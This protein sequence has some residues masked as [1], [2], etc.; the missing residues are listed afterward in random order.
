MNVCPNCFGSEITS[1]VCPLCGYDIG[2]PNADEHALPPGT[3]LSDARYT[4]GGILTQSS[5]GITYYGFDSEKKTRVAVLEYFPDSYA[6]RC[7]TDG[8]YIVCAQKGDTAGDFNKGLQRFESETKR[9]LKIAKLP[10]FAAVLGLVIERGT[11]YIIMEFIDG[12]PLG[13]VI[14]KR[15]GKLSEKIA[16]DLFLPIIKTLGIMHRA[17]FIHRDITPDNILVQKS[18]GK[19]VLIDLGA[20]LEL[21]EEGGDTR[22]TDAML[23]FDYAA[24]ELFDRTSVRQGA[25]TDVYG[26][27][28]TMYI[29][30]TGKKPSDRHKS[31]RENAPSDSADNLS[32]IVKNA[33]MHGTEAEIKSRTRT[34]EQLYSELTGI[35]VTA[36]KTEF[37][38]KT[39]PHDD[40]HILEH[41]HSYSITKI[42]PLASYEGLHINEQIIYNEKTGKAVAFSHQKDGRGAGCN[43]VFIPRKSLKI[44]FPIKVQSVGRERFDLY[45]NQCEIEIDLAYGD[46]YGQTTIKRTEN[47]T[48]DSGFQFSYNHFTTEKFTLNNFWSGKKDGEEFLYDGDTIHKQIS[49]DGTKSPKDSKKYSLIEETDSHKDYIFTEK[50]KAV[51]YSET[52][53]FGSISYKNGDYYRGLIIGGEAC[54]PGVCVY[55]DG[56]IFIGHFVGGVPDGY[57]LYIEPDG[58]AFFVKYDEEDPL[59]RIYIGQISENINLLQSHYLIFLDNIER[60]I[61]KGEFNKAAAELDASK[62]SFTDNSEYYWSKLKI[63]LMVK[64]DNDLKHYDGFINHYSEYKNAFKYADEERRRYFESI[65]DAQAMNNEIFRNITKELIPAGKFDKAKDEMSKIHNDLIEYS[66]YWWTLLKINLKKKTDE[67]LRGCGVNITAMPEYINANK[68]ASMDRK[69]RYLA[70]AKSIKAKV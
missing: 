9:L 51:R 2:A 28:A 61:S 59:E 27:A 65:V 18:D 66:E 68:F 5:F 56:D 58:E 47:G 15:G 45:G 44:S 13:A 48:H 46:N 43:I 8:D 6:E 57:G 36:I 29:A 37:D 60:L 17:G 63:H 25:W 1:N 40:K 67:E 54:G 30:M 53:S 14:N 16:L 4:V 11:A 22:T 26:M 62:V 12:E 31:I 55:A 24:E 34:M 49:V 23:K 19:A 38:D 69:R 52:L 35:P 10:G 64:N 32:E 70:V 21:T 3:K 41:P 20:S 39:K 42:Y 50:V 7:E 33:I